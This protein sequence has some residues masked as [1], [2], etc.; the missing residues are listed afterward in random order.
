MTKKYILSKLKD[1]KPKYED[2]GLVL[3]GLFGSY[4]NDNATEDSDIDILY[5]LEI[6][7]FISNNDGFSGFTRIISIQD[8]LK[9]IFDKNVDLCTINQSSRTFKKFALKSVVYV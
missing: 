5:K 3:L 2:E 1:L 8:E 6:N 4:A 9:E 7:K